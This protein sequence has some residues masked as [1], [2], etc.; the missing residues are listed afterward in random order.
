MSKF[1]V[2]QLLSLTGAQIGWKSVERSSSSELLS[3]DRS[4]LSSSFIDS[5]DSSPRDLKGSHQNS[6]SLVN[7]LDLI[8]SFSDKTRVPPTKSPFTFA[9]KSKKLSQN[10]ER[11]KPDWESIK[12]LGRPRAFSLTLDNDARDSFTGLAS[13]SFSL[14]SLFDGAAIPSNVDDIDRHRF[15]SGLGKRNDQVDKSDQE[16]PFGRDAVE[17][18]DQERGSHEM[19]PAESHD[20]PKVRSRI[21]SGPMGG[22]FSFPFMLESRAMGGQGKESTRSGPK[23]KGKRARER[24]HWDAGEMSGTARSMPWSSILAAATAKR[25]LD[26]PG[27]SVDP[28]G[29]SAGLGKRK[30]KGDNV[31]NVDPNRYFIG[32][33]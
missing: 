30:M 11:K 25:L 12:A 33:G 6:K 27:N 1:Y 23:L 26:P 3:P 21:L 16:N 5:P 2:N 32:L 31:K 17:D 28:W 19:M 10:E 7:F 20:R 9:E 14:A 4:S 22:S 13:R 18:G 24:N 15:F 8:Q 29:Y